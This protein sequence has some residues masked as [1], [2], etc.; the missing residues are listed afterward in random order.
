MFVKLRN[1]RGTTIL[2]NMSI[3]EFCRADARGGTEIIFGSDRKEHLYVLES[4][5]EIMNLLR[6]HSNAG[7]RTPLPT[8]V[9][10][11]GESSG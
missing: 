10:E 4:M 7:L 11:A 8:H 6:S 9:P 1:E 2:L 5:E 3:V